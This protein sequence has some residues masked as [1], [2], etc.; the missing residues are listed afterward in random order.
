MIAG[1]FI[2]VIGYG[3]YGNIRCE[4]PAQIVGQP[5]NCHCGDTEEIL[6]HVII[7]SGIAITTSGMIILGIQLL[8]K[9]RMQS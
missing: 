9:N 8:K 5:S 1:L 4:C 7:Y 6:G 3:Q 2:S